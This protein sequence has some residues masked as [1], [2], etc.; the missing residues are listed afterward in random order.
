[1]ATKTKTPRMQEAV[2]VMMQK[3]VNH[4]RDNGWDAEA[5][6]RRAAAVP[7]QNV[8]KTLLVYRSRLVTPVGP[9]LPKKIPKTNH[10]PFEDNIPM[11]AW[12]RTLEASGLSRGLLPCKATFS[13]GGRNEPRQTTR[14]PKK[15][16]RKRPRPE[17]GS[18]KLASDLTDVEKMRVMKTREDAKARGE[19]ISLQRLEAMFGMRDAHGMTAARAIKAAKEFKDKQ[20][21]LATIIEMLLDGASYREI[22]KE[23]GAGAGTNGKTSWKI[24]RRLGLKSQGPR[25]K[26]KEK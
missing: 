11:W 21:R 19:N 6:A 15:P 22:D 12:I 16:A 9:G 1:M 13:P 4:A 10:E 3:V 5:L 18:G 14:K 7:D 26:K 2:K 17:P 8:V 20:P 25:A 24:A 23:I